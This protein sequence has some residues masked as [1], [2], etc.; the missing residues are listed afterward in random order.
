MQTPAPPITW[1]TSTYLATAVTA[2]WTAIPTATMENTPIPATNAPT[3]PLPTPII[4][5]PHT[6]R[7]SNNAPT[8]P[9]APLVVLTGLL[10]VLYGILYGKFR[11][12]E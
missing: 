3:A 10:I 4:V 8:L 12:R 7:P 1:P 5:V 6:G 11:R 9:Y 2:T